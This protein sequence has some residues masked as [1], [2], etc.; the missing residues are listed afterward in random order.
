MS[1]LNFSTAWLTY[2]IIHAC[3]YITVKRVVTL[4][5]FG[6]TVK[7]LQ[8]PASVSEQIKMS[9]LY[10]QREPTITIFEIIGKCPS[11]VAHTL[12]SLPV[13]NLVTSIIVFVA[14]VCKKQYR[15]YSHI[16]SKKLFFITGDGLAC[17]YYSIN[18]KHALT[19]N[20]LFTQLYNTLFNYVELWKP[21][22]KM[23]MVVPC[24]LM[25]LIICQF[26]NM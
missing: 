14:F 15:I 17:S 22:C 8:Q 9:L 11:L 1:N 6:H 16:D 10:A 7:P 18:H 20:T 23:D 4:N 2:V 12:S 5:F 3:F 13:A 21:L 25:S 24:I 26:T 19:R